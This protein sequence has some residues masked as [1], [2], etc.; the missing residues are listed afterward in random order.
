LLIS[1]SDKL[2][3]KLLNAKVYQMFTLQ[4]T[5]IL[6]GISFY[7]LLLISITHVFGKQYRKYTL[8][9]LAPLFSFSFGFL[10]RLNPNEEIVDVGFFF[11]ESSLMFS[12]LLLTLTML[13][14]QLKYWKK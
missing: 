7:S 8:F 14:G 2:A 1:V 6:I 3:Y 12:Y 5:L 9:L 11:T 10:L 4:L 13:M